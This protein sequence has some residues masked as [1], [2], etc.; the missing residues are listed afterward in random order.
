MDLQS[1]SQNDQPH[2]PLT[3]AQY[4]TLLTPCA[5]TCLVACE[6]LSAEQRICLPGL[7]TD[8]SGMIHMIPQP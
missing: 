3:A 8:G 2:P 4:Q 7:H 1:W 6:A 5:A